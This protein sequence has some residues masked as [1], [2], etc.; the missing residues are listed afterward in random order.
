MPYRVTKEEIPAVPESAEQTCDFCNAFLW[1][2]GPEV[3]EGR[4]AA[5]E[6]PSSASLVVQ[7]TEGLTE[8]MLCQNCTT[9][10]I[11]PMIVKA[12]QETSLE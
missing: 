9:K 1:R 2:V 11:N 3:P 5:K 4:Q 6:N 10:Y 12:R 8:F 7:T